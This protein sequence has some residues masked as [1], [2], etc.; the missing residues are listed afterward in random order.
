MGG[1]QKACPTMKARRAHRAL[2][3][4]DQFRI[5]VRLPIDKF[6]LVN[7]VAAYNHTP[8]IT[9]FNKSGSLMLK[10]VSDIGFFKHQLWH[11]R[12]HNT[13]YSIIFS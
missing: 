12:T 3:F 10:P 11:Q 6:L 7:A 9:I 2:D 1:E 13:S 4:F 8:Y 5:I